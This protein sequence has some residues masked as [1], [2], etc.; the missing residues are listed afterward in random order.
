MLERLISGGR[1]SRS[2]E[3]KSIV[4]ETNVQRLVALQTAHASS[5]SYVVV[6]A[7]SLPLNVRV[8]KHLAVFLGL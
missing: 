2:G 4:V 5:A 1:R 7:D 8:V 6:I 3:P